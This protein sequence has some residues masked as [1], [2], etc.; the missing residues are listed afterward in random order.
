MTLV[1]Y[2]DISD[3]SDQHRENADLNGKDSSHPHYNYVFEQCR[4][5]IKDLQ[6][7]RGIDDTDV[8]KETNLTTASAS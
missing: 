7:N 6:I 4:C 5:I 8:E 3:K 1:T 2:C